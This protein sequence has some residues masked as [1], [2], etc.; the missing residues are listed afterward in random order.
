MNIQVRTNTRLLR[1]EYEEL[2]IECHSLS[3]RD[4]VT[5]YVK[6]CVCLI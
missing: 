2:Q 1:D 3:P 5:Y 4:D 6:L